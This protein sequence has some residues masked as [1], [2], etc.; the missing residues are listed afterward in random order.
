M[1]WEETADVSVV[2]LLRKEAQQALNVWS[3]ACALL[4]H[5]CKHQNQHLDQM[6]L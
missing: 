1:G 4:L 6:I 3:A 2:V 5:T